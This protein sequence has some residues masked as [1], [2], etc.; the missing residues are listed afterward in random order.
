ML[1]WSYLGVQ[2][3]WILSNRIRIQ[4]SADIYI[5]I[6]IF[7]DMNTDTDIF[8]YEYGYGYFRI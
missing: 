2:T 3:E 4:T 7:S 8:G 6:R 1:I 5:Q